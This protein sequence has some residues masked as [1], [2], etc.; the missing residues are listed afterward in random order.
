MTIEQLD[1]TVVAV[2]IPGPVPGP[3]RDG[4]RLRRALQFEV[5]KAKIPRR[6]LMHF[7]RQLG[8]FIRAGVPLL[9]ALETILSENGHKYFRKVLTDTVEGLRSGLTLSAAIHRYADA[10]PPYYLGIVRSAELTGNLDTALQQLSDYLERDLEA[11]RK[12]TSALT[13]PAIVA[14]MSVIV[15]AILAG[16]VL[17]KFE[18]FFHSLQA[19]LPLPTRILLTVSHLARTHWY[20]LAGLAGMVVVAGFLLTRTERGLRLRDRAALHVPVLGDLLH[21]IVLERF[22]RVLGSLVSS[23]ITMPDALAV[24]SDAT[25]NRVYQKALAQVRAAMLRGEGVAAP[26][27]ATG[28]FPAAARQMFR[29]G[30]ETGSLDDQLGV[31]AEFYSREL[32]HKIKRFANIFEPLVIVAVGLLVGFVA[33][34]LVSAMYGIYRQVKV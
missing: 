34:A 2:G 7:S 29:I 4:S 23:G 31:A 25:N 9:E 18:V 5:T 21:H 33:I 20:V 6:E 1:P 10:F 12:V 11:R 19:K 13:Y 26:L 27:A 30:E 17:P 8:V 16:Y 24:S 14:G 3:R 28:L 32:D 22:C 15:V